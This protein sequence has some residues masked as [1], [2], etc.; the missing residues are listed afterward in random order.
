MKRYCA[1]K[2][3]TCAEELVTLMDEGK[4]IYYRHKYIHAGFWTSMSYRVIRNALKAGYLS[5]VNIIARKK[6][7]LLIRDKCEEVFVTLEKL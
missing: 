7:G 4:P 5:H 6:I 1:G 2:T 3:I